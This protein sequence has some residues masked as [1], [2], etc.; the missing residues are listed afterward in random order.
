MLLIKYVSTLLSLLILG[1][2]ALIIYR[3]PKKIDNRVFFVVCALSALWG[4]TYQNIETFNSIATVSRLSSAAYLWGVL[5]MLSV[6]W[7]TYVFPIRRPARSFVI[8][9]IASLPVALISVTP[10]IAG[11][12]S[13]NKADGTFHFTYGP[14]SDLYTLVMVVGLGIIIANLLRNKKSLDAV[15][16]SQARTVAFGFIASFIA[17]VSLSVLVPR[18]FV[19]SGIDNFAPFSLI[20]LIFFTAFAMSRHKLFDFRLVVARSLAYLLT[21][22][23]VIA[24]Y[25]TVVSVIFV[26]LNVDAAGDFTQKTLYLVIAVT[27]GLTFPSLKRFFDKF[28][29]GIFYRDAY[30]SQELLNEFNKV[31]VS[32]I[33]LSQLLIRSGET[34]AKYIKPEFIYFGVREADDIRIISND[35]VRTESSG[36]T[37]IRKFEKTQKNKLFVA[38]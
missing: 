3:N 14:L 24:I 4:L 20:F 36:I 37:S 27:L 1:V 18:V 19:N 21:F 34:I 28:T 38:E 12:V 15:Q 5:L 31:I 7:F 26:G 11:E 9:L 30:D 33:D 22:S 6:V 17:G 10:L 32:T 8:Y 23:S 35:S 29:N 16:K 13:I 25:S 2:G